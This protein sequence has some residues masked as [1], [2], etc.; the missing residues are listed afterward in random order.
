MEKITQAFLLAA[1][2]GTRMLHLTDDKP[3]PLVEVAGKSLI[4]YN[5]EHSLRAGV[6]DCIVNL[7]YKGDMIRD[8]LT[9]TFPN[10]HFIFSDEEEALETGGGI[11][12]ALP[13]MKNEPFFVINSDALWAEDGEETILKQMN[14]AWD[15]DKYDMMLMLQPIEKAYGVG[16]NGD[17]LVEDGYPVRRRDKETKAPYL[18]GGIMICHPRVFDNE[19]EGKYSLVRIFDRLENAKRLGY[20]IHQGSWFHVGDPT[21]KEVAEAHFSKSLAG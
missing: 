7:C 12:N 16:A 19:P 21:A 1:G 2:R 13:K 20:Y 15:S 10:V 9:A 17:Y 5:V 11:K 4:D 14:K 8:H 6:K 18:Y 3:K